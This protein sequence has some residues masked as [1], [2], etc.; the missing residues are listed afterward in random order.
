M[1]DTLLSQIGFAVALLVGCFA[2]L[3]GDEPERIGAGAYLLAMMS[4]Q[5]VHDG[6]R[7]YGFNAGLLAVDSLFLAVCVGLAWKSRRAW[8]VWACA[9]TALIIMS[10]MVLLTDLRPPLAAFYAVMNLASY[11]VL[12][13]IAAGTLRAWRDRRA[14]GLT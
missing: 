11:G 14:E 8:P 10:H 5:L 7:L 6:S 9:F 2:F 1:F 13:A 4:S 12:A 3:K